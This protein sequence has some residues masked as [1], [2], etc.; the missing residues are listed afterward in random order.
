MLTLRSPAKVNLFLRILGKRPD[1]YHELASLFQTVS[2]FDI[3]HF[4]F[5]DKDSLTCTDA[6][7]PLNSSNLIWK[8]V[9]LF[10]QKTGRQASLSVHLEKNIPMQAGLGGGSSNAATA[11][12]ALNQL[13]GQPATIEELIKWGSQ[14]GSDV[15][16]FLSNGTAYCTGR[17]EHIRPLAP[18]PNTSLLLVKP[19][20]GLSTPAIYA[21]LKLSSLS[22]RDPEASLE[23]WIKGEPQYFND[24]E[25]A[26]FLQM[27]KLKNLRQQLLNDGFQHV[28]L[29]G[30]GSSLFCIGEGRQFPGYFC[31]QT[32]FCNRSSDRWY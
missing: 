22:K 15:A 25:E 14:I 13:S 6:S 7:L 24:L 8:A 10:R 23:S 28:L 19:R 12:W 2:L 27:P 3:I 18:L 30:S 4:T 1:G 11:L 5:S 29:C 31:K 26:A 21:A 17:G 20:E 16:F 9:D 32:S